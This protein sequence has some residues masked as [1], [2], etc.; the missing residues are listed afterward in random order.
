MTD[1]FQVSYAH[2]MEIWSQLI[3][4]AFSGK[5]VLVLHS[6]LGILLHTQDADSQLLRWGRAG[7]Q[8]KYFP[9][10]FA[11]ASESFE[12]ISKFILAKQ[13]LSL[14]FYQWGMGRKILL[15][16]SFFFGKEVM[17]DIGEITE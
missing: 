14:H 13:I 10:L 16:N 6:H 12:F 9:L 7:Q 2:A 4:L 17:W 8:L 15:N 5:S 1:C 11:S 3:A